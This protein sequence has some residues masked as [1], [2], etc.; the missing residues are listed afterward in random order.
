MGLPLQHLHTLPLT[1]VRLDA[2]VVQRLD[3]DKKAVAL[4]QGFIA[5]GRSLGLWVAA[6]GVETPQQLATLQKLGCKFAL[7]SG[8][9]W[10]QALVPTGSPLVEP[11][12][13]VTLVHGW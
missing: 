4:C 2:K 5:L 9:A 1:A 7:G 11:R 12:G 6:E 10:P 13:D 8:V 3:Y